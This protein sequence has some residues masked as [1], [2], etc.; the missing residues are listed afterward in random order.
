VRDT[1]IAIAPPAYSVSARV[2]HWLTAVLVLAMVPLGIVIANEWGGPLQERLYNLHRSVG[3]LLIPIV[4]VRL[5]YRL[6]HPPLPLTADI[7]LIQQRAAHAVHWTLYALLLVQ[8][9]VGWV[10]TSAYRAPMPMFGLFELPPIWPVDRSLSG[11]LFV[12][13]RTIGIVIA[14]IATVHIAAALYHHFVRRDR[15]L[16]RM[17]TG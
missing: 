12:V 7:P 13:H 15:V 8:P 3:A 11:Q 1:T 17:I 5:L 9:F 6:T 10:A 16:M 14:A 2:L 4:I